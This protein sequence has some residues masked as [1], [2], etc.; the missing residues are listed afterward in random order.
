MKQRMKTK[1]RYVIQYRLTS[2]KWVDDSGYPKYRES[3]EAVA[4]LQYLRRAGMY[5][6]DTRVI[7]RETTVRDIPFY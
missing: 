5:S 1:V 6:T 7:R 3:T 2:G 4:Q